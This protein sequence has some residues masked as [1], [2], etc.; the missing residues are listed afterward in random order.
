M[1]D[2]AIV[3]RVMD[4]T[5]PGL[6]SAG[7]NVGKLDKRV[8]SLGKTANVA[9]L[10]IAGIATAG[11][12]LGVA[13]AASIAKG[14][15]SL[16]DFE[17]E[18]RPMVERS[19]LAAESLQVLAEAA[20]RAGSEDGLEAVVD[21]SQEL[22]LQLGELAATGKGRALD[23]LT[24]LGLV[25]EDL[26]EQS[27]EEAFRNVLAEI[28]K[29]P[30]VADRAI[31]AEDIFGGTSEKLAGI[32]NLTTAE[33]AALEKEVIAT[34]DIW[35]GE[36]LASAKE[37][38]LEMQ[39][40]TTEIGRGRNAL[41]VDLLPALTTIVKFIRTDV[42]PAWQDFKAKAIAPVKDFIVDDLI[43]A[44]E[45]VVEV[46][47]HMADAFKQDGPMEA[48]WVLNDFMDGKLRPAIDAIYTAFEVFSIGGHV[49]DAFKRD[50]PME[51]LW[52]LNDFMDGKLRP[53]IDAIY[54]SMDLLAKYIPT[55][56][57][58]SLSD[59][60]VEIRDHLE[61]TIRIVGETIRTILFP[62]MKAIKLIIDNVVLPALEALWK[63]FGEDIVKAA[64]KASDAFADLRDFVKDDLIPTLSD[65][66]VEIRDNLE[67][68][69]EATGETIRTILVPKM[70]AIKLIIDNVVLPALKALWRILWG[71][72]T[73]SLRKGQ[74]RHLVLHGYGPPGDQDGLG[75]EGQARPDEY[76]GYPYDRGCASRRDHQG[77]VQ[78][79]VG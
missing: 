45:K 28:Q 33:F 71:R 41:I 53:A 22:Q 20:T 36:A 67:P 63:Y 70:K 73:R 4:K 78:R 12:G 5:K 10:A 31:A 77:E 21:S 56:F 6:R 40:L 8:G 2:L 76:M 13:F 62:Q 64:E 72:D 25:W 7:A 27:P 61:P 29:I 42:L 46:G 47:G 39:H 69:I 38:G 68:V 30:N 24:S 18:L 23:A 44:I 54:D 9:K 32:V 49:A 11:I 19:R 65:L 66:H 59:L 16:V 14:V 3:A 55:D 74:G 43:P 50:G 57:V 17:K 1:A 15:K 75:G 60:N 79:A 58:P 26:K 35:S 48:L 52:V 37:F 34:S 51:A